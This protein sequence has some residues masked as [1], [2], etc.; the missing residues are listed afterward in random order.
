MEKV[1]AVYKSG[2]FVGEV[3]F[4]DYREANAH[5]EKVNLAS[6]I[7][8]NVNFHWNNDF[9]MNLAEAIL[10]KYSVSEKYN[11]EEYSDVEKTVKGDE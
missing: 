1:E 10:G 6:F 7:S 11:Y 9:A 3:F 5:A 2:Y 8:E 4:S